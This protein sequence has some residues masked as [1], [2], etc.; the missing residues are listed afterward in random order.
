MQMPAAHTLPVV[1]GIG[2]RAPHYR[3]VI[4]VFQQTVKVLNDWLEFIKKCSGEAHEASIIFLFIGAD[5]KLC[6]RHIAR[7]FGSKRYFC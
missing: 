3:T 6:S 5:Y 2:L 7:T 1:A 4:G